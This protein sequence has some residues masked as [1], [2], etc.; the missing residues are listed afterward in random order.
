MQSVEKEELR[1]Q[2]RHHWAG[3]GFCAEMR[4]LKVEAGIF[5]EVSLKT[6]DTQ[7]RN[8]TTYTEC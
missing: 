2:R 1:P 8:E 4:Y 7:R 3:V 5:H 6:L